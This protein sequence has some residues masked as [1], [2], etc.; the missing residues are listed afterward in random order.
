MSRIRR[1]E[2]LRAGAAAL[3]VSA[4]GCA[5]SET[6]TDTP[7]G[8]GAHRTTAAERRQVTDAPSPRAQFRFVNA[9][10]DTTPVA[11]V[12][13]GVPVF[14]EVSFREVTPYSFLPPGS[15]ELTVDAEDRPAGAV[16]EGKIDL[17]VGAYTA[18]LLAPATAAPEALEATAESGEGG[19]PRSSPVVKLF[20]DARPAAGSERARI[21]FVNACPDAPPLDVLVSGRTEPLVENV[22]FR[23]AASATVAPKTYE[24]RV[25]GP[26][27]GGRRV[28][29]TTEISVRPDAAYT[30]FA[31]GYVTPTDEPESDSFG[32]DVTVNQSVGGE[33]IG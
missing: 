30:I 14:R 33:P 1:R 27:D 23:E 5:G 16:F 4:A 17:G 10:P 13:R 32:L 12:V 2:L 26:A 8:A 7:L 11:V 18:A 9:A 29:G 31:F 22:A 20:R 28:F 15:L 24:V 25:A 21:Q 3:G 6:A 19:E